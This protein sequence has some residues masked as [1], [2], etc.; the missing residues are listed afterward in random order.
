MVSILFIFRGFGDHGVSLTCVD[1]LSFSALEFFV[2]IHFGQLQLV[3]RG[4]DAHILIILSEILYIFNLENFRDIYYCTL[5]YAR[6]KL[7]LL[8]SSI[9]PIHLSNLA[10]QCS[11]LA[12][13]DFFLKEREKAT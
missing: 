6:T 4:S 5:D 7:H 2:R 3:R 11:S 12:R 1:C 10:W 13:K 9:C 8:Q